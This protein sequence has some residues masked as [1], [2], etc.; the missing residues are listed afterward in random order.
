[1]KTEIDVH[2][3]Q[4]KILRVLLFKPKARFRDLNIEDL[5]TDHFS[6]HIKQLVASD[7]IHKHKDGSY[8]LTVK[9]K[10]FANHFDTDKVS[11][12]PQAKIGVLIAGVKEEH[13]VKKYLIQQRLKQP[14]FGFHGCPGGKVRKGETIFEAASRELKE[15]TG[16][17]GK[18]KLKAVKHKMDYSPNGKLLEDKFFF[19]FIAENLSGKLIEKFEGGRNLW[20]TEKEIYQLPKLFKDVSQTIEFAKRKDL[21]FSEKKYTEEIF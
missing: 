2:N 12:E 9:G 19:L 13:G 6:F 18:L 10:E 3:V 11:V 17:K 5:S 1:M 20:L 7:L 21:Q 8:E 4:A 15:E 14:Y 16:L